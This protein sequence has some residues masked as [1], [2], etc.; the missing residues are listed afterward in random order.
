MDENKKQDAERKVRDGNTCIGMGVG[1]GAISA[2]AAA[3]TGA[4]C[5][6]C[7]VAVPALLGM[8]L[9]ERNQGKKLEQQEP[10]SSENE[11]T[12]KVKA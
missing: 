7:Y 8:G 1:L 3:I 2:G 12:A 4:V 10:Q 6:I 5:P 9:Y 11:S